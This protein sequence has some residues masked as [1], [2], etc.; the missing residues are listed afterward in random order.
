MRWLVALA[1]VLAGCKYPFVP[2]EAA[3]LNTRAIA[4][5]AAAPTGRL[6]SSS[7]GG[8]ELGELL[9]VHD[10]TVVV[11]YRGFY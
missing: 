1:I 4:V 7:G 10:K 6:T 3:H 2:V 11:F 5:G 8:V 9:R